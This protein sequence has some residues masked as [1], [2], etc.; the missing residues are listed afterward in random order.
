M[1]HGTDVT[2][3][4]RIYRMIVH[5]ALRRAPLVIANSQATAEE[6]IAIGVRRERVSVVRLGVAA[7]PT[8]QQSRQEA[9]D[10]LRRQFDIGDD[11]VILVTLGRLVRRKGVVWFVGNC[12][13]PARQRDV[14]GRR[15][16][17]Y[18]P[19][20]PAR[21]RGFRPED[22]SMC[23]EQSMMRIANACFAAPTFSPA[24]HSRPRRH[25]SSGPVLLEPQCAAHPR[26][27]AGPKA[28]SMPWSTVDGIPGSGRGRTRLDRTGVRLV[29]TPG[30]LRGIGARFEQAARALYSE[31]QMSRELLR[32][33]SAGH[34]SA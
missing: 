15:R 18:G 30:A 34:H 31:E 17:P 1:I 23:W 2:Y 6:A 7:P 16:W 13:P 3:P 33:L 22:R 8:S 32:L 10:S 12:W 5:P 27:P 24:Q 9:A 28:T 19:R 26:L 11:Q 21:G 14:S 20:A 4:N 25:G 29:T